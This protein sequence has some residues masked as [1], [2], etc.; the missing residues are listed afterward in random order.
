MYGI[1]FAVI[2]FILAFTGACFAFILIFAKA[3]APDKSKKYTVVCILD[4]EDEHGVLRLRWIYNA[5]NILGLREYFRIAAVVE[6][7]QGNEIE[8]LKNIFTDKEMVFIC[9]KDNLFKK[10]QK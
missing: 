7:T 6:E 1:I 10:I 2:L 5:V 4:K 8:Q 9:T 3:S